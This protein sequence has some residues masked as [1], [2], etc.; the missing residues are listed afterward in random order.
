MFAEPEAREKYLPDDPEDITYGVDEI[1][2]LSSA[3][4]LPCAS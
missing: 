1:V 2:F 4:T 3:R